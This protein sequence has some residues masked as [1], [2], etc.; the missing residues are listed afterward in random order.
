MFPDWFLKPESLF[1]TLLWVL[2]PLLAW[3]VGK[4]LIQRF[5]AWNE[6]TSETAARASLTYLYKALENPPSLLE[7]VA[8]IVC[9][10]PVPVA[11][12]MMFGV[13]YLMPFPLPHLQLDPELAQKMRASFL[14]L[15]FLFNYLLFGVL[16]VHGITVAYRLRHG[17]PR[18]AENYK[19]GIQKRIDRLRKKY[20]RL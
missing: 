16:A 19:A 17:E 4:K 8:Y 18:Y 13:L 1:R 5:E 20:P 2:S 6:A 10:L 7:S 9:F 14:Y 3:F 11:L 12:T 15:A